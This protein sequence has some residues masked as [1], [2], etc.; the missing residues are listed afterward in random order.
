MRLAWISGVTFALAWPVSA[1][2]CMPQ[3]FSGV[4]GFQLEGSTTISGSAKPVASMGRLEFDGQGGV[5][6]VSSVNF[7]G[8]FLGNPVTGNYEVRADCRITWSLQDD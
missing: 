2:Y 8:Y 1:Q 4:Y 5:S 3:K 6:G 7:A